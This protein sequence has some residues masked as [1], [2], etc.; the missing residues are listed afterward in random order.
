MTTIKLTYLVPQGPR[1]KARR[2]AAQ[3]PNRIRTPQNR[4]NHSSHTFK[5]RNARTLGHAH[6]Q[7]IRQAVIFP[8]TASSIPYILPR[9]RQ[10]HLGSRPQ[11]LS[12]ILVFPASTAIIRPLFV[13]TSATTTTDAPHNRRNCGSRNPRPGFTDWKTPLHRT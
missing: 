13:L 9:Q 3:L 10:Q 7:R 2:A 5:Q 4:T 12:S 11:I 1:R 6:R 8:A